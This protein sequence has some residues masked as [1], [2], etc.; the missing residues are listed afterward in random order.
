[1]ASPNPARNASWMSRNE[2]RG[3]AS[4][5]AFAVA[6]L[7]CLAIACLAALAP[8]AADP[9]ADATTATAEPFPALDPA[10]GDGDAG[11][12]GDGGVGDCS[13][14]GFGKRR[15]TS[16]RGSPRASAAVAFGER[17]AL[18]HLGPVIVNADCSVRRITNWAGLSERERRGTSARVAARNAE[19]LERCR[20]AA[21]EG[22]LEGWDE[23]GDE[24]E[25]GAEGERR[26]VRPSAEGRENC[27]APC[28]EGWGGAR[29][30]DGRDEY[31][32]WIQAGWRGNVRPSRGCH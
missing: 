20:A 29:R 17:V 22:T 6:L 25:G 26:R 16:A 15:G 32:R 14:R 8:A 19:R 24:G 4:P 10:R 28:G 13:V 30:R 3:R 18:D 7:A 21:S 11:E 1:M 9:T 27:D 23:A 5:P 12:A 31:T 2:P